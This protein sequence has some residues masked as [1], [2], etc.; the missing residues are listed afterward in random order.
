MPK[1]LAIVAALVAALAFAAPAHAAS[2][3]ACGTVHGDRVS[4][5]RATSCTLAKRVA[6]HDPDDFADGRRVPVKS[7]ATGRT[8]RFF[9]WYQDG[10]RWVVH[11]NG[12]HD[13]TLGVQ[14][15]T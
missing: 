4:A 5:N 10:K 6:R 12:E 14:V 15:R 9:L 3:K 7:P 8:Y 11:A 2:W 1:L 13:T